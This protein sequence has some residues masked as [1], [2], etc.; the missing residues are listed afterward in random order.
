MNLRKFALIITV[1]YLLFIHTEVKAFD[2][3][4]FLSKIEQKLFNTQ[5]NN[6][7]INT[8]VNRIEK[9]V[10]GSVGTGTTEREIER[11]KHTYGYLVPVDK[12]SSKNATS[13]STKTAKAVKNKP[14]E[15]LTYSPQTLMLT[16]PREKA[17]SDIQYPAINAME[18]KILS[19]S[20]EKE[21]I[22]KRVQRLEIIVFKQNFNEPL[23][24]RVDRLKTVILGN[25]N[26]SQGKMV[27]GGNLSEN[28]SE[29]MSPDSVNTLLNGIEKS[30]FNTTYPSDSVESR[31][32]RL[33]TKIFNQTSPDDSVQDRIER[34]A[35]VVNA[36]P[37]NEMYK[38][39]SQVRKY[40]Q[41]GTGITAAAILLLLL[42]GLL[43]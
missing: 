19:R 41:V 30:T 4:A 3:S 2:N 22:Y 8:R 31:L 35:A 14:D 27:N 33:E 43:F 11:L 21:D 38:D 37:S 25:N 6:E 20:F 15:K 16:P 10:F 23:N 26:N 29:P 39:M 32:S 28:N 18:E 9:N 1:I 42:R 13:K 17:N 36:Q 24:D 40:Q 5:F 34:L 12:P 7:Q